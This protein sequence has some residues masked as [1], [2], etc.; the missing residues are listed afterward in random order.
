VLSSSPSLLASKRNKGA[1]RLRRGKMAPATSA[2]ITPHRHQHR[3]RRMTSRSKSKLHSFL[4]KINTQSEP[5]KDRIKMQRPGEVAIASDPDVTTE[6]RKN[7]V[8]LKKAV[9]GP[10]KKRPA[11]KSTKGNHFNTNESG[12]LSALEKSSLHHNKPPKKYT[13]KKAVM[14][15]AFEKEPLLAPHHLTPKTNR[16]NAILHHRR[17]SE[18]SYSPLEHRPDNSVNDNSKFLKNV[19]TTPMLKSYVEQSTKPSPENNHDSSKNI[20]DRCDANVGEKKGGELFVN[21]PNKSDDPSSSSVIS[22]SSNSENH[23]EGK[24]CGSDTI[25]KSKQLFTKAS[26]AG[27]GDITH[28][29]GRGCS[30]NSMSPSKINEHLEVEY[31]RLAFL[32]L[33]LERKMQMEKTDAEKIRPWMYNSPITGMGAMV[34]SNNMMTDGGKENN[35]SMICHSGKSGNNNDVAREFPP[36]REAVAFGEM[37]YQR[38]MAEQSSAKSWNGG[39]REEKEESAASTDVTNHER[40]RQRAPKYPGIGH[41][42]EE[43]GKELNHLERDEYLGRGN[44]SRST[45]RPSTKPIPK[46]KKRKRRV[47]ETITRVIHEE[48]EEEGSTSIGD[49]GRQSR[50]YFESPPKEN[51]FV[52]SRKY[53][54]YDNDRNHVA[55]ESYAGRSGI[56]RKRIYPPDRE[57]PG[58]QHRCGKSYDV[59][60]GNGEYV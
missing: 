28:D 50:A 32:K 25:V 37:A 44:N 54:G 11:N 26:D 59:D 14:S 47:V 13:T 57:A 31:G 40:K 16:A 42:R 58:L 39:R 27:D 29:G 23:E 4:A 30:G 49:E 9:A 22:T 46:K 34:S 1:E 55:N 19:A 60:L 48:S 21:S 20:Y 5:K 10:T 56:S 6:A 45:F 24:E 53:H 7:S 18:D 41:K 36:S 33:D 3:Q 52:R 51:Q 2:P 38:I 35:D 43:R 8:S 15:S 17:S 12:S